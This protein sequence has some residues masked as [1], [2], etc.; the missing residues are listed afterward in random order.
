MRSSVQC[1]TSTFM[2]DKAASVRAREKPAY[3]GRHRLS[4]CGKPDKHGNYT[5]TGEFGMKQAKDDPASMSINGVLRRNEAGVWDVS[6]RNK[7]RRSSGLPV[8]LRRSRVY[9]HRQGPAILPTLRDWGK[10]G[11]RIYQMVHDFPVWAHCP[12]CGKLNEIRFI[13]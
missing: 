13:D 12:K 7:R 8:R 1:R 3:D 10:Q 11:D 4:L 6:E 5:C 9:D 2:D